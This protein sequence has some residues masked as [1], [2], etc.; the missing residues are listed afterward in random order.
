MSLTRSESA[1]AK[2]ISRTVSG[3][4]LC[5]ALAQPALAQETPES[6]T[7]DTVVVTGQTERVSAPTAA[8]T[9]RTSTPIEEIPESV[10]VLTR[11]LTLEVMEAMVFDEPEMPPEGFEEPAAEPEPETVSAKI[12]RFI[13][14]L[15]GLSS[16][17]PAPEQQQ[18]VESMPPDFSAP[19]NF[20]P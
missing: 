5:W 19:G 1:S 11:T 13:L 12:W 8:T 7:R 2:T 6:W 20:G 9:T 18:P 4:A 17:A 16:G 10:Q 3:V 15:L 14:G